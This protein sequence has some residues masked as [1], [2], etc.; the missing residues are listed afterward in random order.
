MKKIYTSM[1]A[2]SLGAFC[3]LTLS[4]QE[5]LNITF[6]DNQLPAKWEVSN[7]GTYSFENGHLNV[8]MSNQKT[9]GTNSYR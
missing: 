4:A 7:G 6:A 5:Q 1:I 9:D 3:G 2:L 8:M